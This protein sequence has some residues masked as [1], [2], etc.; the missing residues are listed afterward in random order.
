MTNAVGVVPPLLLPCSFRSRTTPFAAVVP[1]PKR[2]WKGGQP[3]HCTVASKLVA[4]RDRPFVPWLGKI[5][6]RVRTALVKNR[7]KTSSQPP[8]TSLYADK[9]MDSSDTTS[10][11]KSTRGIPSKTISTRPVCSCGGFKPHT[12]NMGRPTDGDMEIGGPPV[13]IPCACDVCLAC[14]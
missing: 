5:S 11:G 6:C 12:G 3:W 14:C 2:G 7:S 9:N 1:S 10:A 4:S 8:V 13:V